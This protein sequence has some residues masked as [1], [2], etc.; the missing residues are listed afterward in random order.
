METVLTKRH[1]SKSQYLRGRQCLKSLWLYKFKPEL[2]DQIGLEQQAIF[3]AGTEVGILAQDYFPGGVLVPYD[4]LTLAE[5]TD[6]TRLAIDAGSNVIYEATFQYQG[7][8]VKADILV[9]GTD[10]WELYEVKGSTAVKDVYL[11]DIAVQQYVLAGSGSPVSRAHLI[12]VDNRYVRQGPIDLKQL[13]RVVDVSSAVK[14]YLSSVPSQLEQMR[15]A[16]QG[17]MPCITIGPHCNSPYPCDFAGHCW[18]HIPSPSVFDLERIGKKGY[19]LYQKGFL[20]LEDVPPERL[21]TRQ[22]MQQQ[23][24]INK[25]NFIDIET[26]KGF[27]SSI[28]LP[29][30]FVDFETV[31]TAIP[32]FDNVR[33]YQQV[34]FQFSVHIIERWDMPPV[35]K[36]YLATGVVGPQRKFVETLLSVIPDGVHVVVWNKA[37]EKTRLLELAELFPEY[38]E[39]LVKISASLCDLMEPFRRR[40]IYHWQFQGS[41]SIKKVL[42]VLVPELSYDDLGIQSGEVASREWLRVLSTTDNEEQQRVHNQL[43]AY[44][45]LDTY[46]MVRIF[47]TLI[48]ATR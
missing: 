7:V 40:D 17:E 19:E 10:G 22:L 1:L 34:P 38:R 35:H 44:C 32:L 14:P 20:K 31:S 39:R 43:R 37:F 21:N 4:G 47:Q 6:K 11:E 41:Y 23:A 16:I 24:W 26:V 9:R 2:R 33:P 8:L 30:Y 42:P 18:A 29:L 12:H 28:S 5:Q 45:Q 15:A 36:E 3:N 13:F 25:T 48:D 46:A 27:L